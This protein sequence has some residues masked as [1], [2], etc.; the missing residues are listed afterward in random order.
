MMALGS[1]ALMR[2]VRTAW[3]PFAAVLGL[4]LFAPLIAQGQGVD[5]VVV[6]WT[7]PGDDGSLGT[8]ANYDLRFSLSQIN[9]SNFNSATPVNGLPAPRVAG[10][11][12][13]VTVRGLVRGTTYWFAL[14][15]RDDEGNLSP[16]SNL[17]R[18]EWQLDT[19]PPGA[20]NGVN[21]SRDGEDVRIRWNPSPEPDLLG[22]RVY[23]ATSQSGPYV[24]A[25]GGLI[26]ATEFLDTN[27]PDGTSTVWY[28]I[29]AQDL[30]GNES[31]RT[32][33]SVNLN[34]TNATTAGISVAECYPN[35]SNVYGPVNIPVT[36]PAGGLNDVAVENLDSGSRRVRRLEVG[37]MA[38]GTQD[39]V[40]DGKNDAGRMCAP[41]V[42]RG[43]V[44]SGAERQSIR[45][46][47]VP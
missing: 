10:S 25:S 29:S 11:R 2:L 12:E 23:R 31:A 28:Q 7:A 42:Y 17:V 1:R 9:D 40:W 14:K 5:T 43:W 8:A 37:A 19:A 27:V 46:V 3:F 26:T 30:N 21:A 47:R 13:Q 22:Y 41:G 18:W 16:I 15:T 45:L 24:L 38:A 33:V 36:V 34:E 6:R 44:I 4:L 20:P 32:F 35:P 39:I